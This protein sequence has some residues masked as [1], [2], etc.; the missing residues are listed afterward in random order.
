[1]SWQWGMWGDLAGR[2]SLVEQEQS[3]GCAFVFGLQAEDLSEAEAL[4]FEVVCL[5]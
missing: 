1:M 3:Q 2:P 4:L 5:R